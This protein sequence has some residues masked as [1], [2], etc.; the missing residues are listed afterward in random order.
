MANC[1]YESIPKKEKLKYFSDKQFGKATK[2]AS[3]KIFAVVFVAVAAMG[4]WG[5]QA[6]QNNLVQNLNGAVAD[7]AKVLGGLATILSNP[8]NLLNGQLGSNVG[9]LVNRIVVLV[10]SLL[11]TVTELLIALGLAS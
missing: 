1:R 2:M 4:I 8:Q 3:K 6:Q 5:V 10:G 7:L 9:E 11:R